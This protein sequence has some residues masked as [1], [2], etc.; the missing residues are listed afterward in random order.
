M[1]G[2]INAAFDNLRGRS[3]LD[4]SPLAEDLIALLSQYDQAEQFSLDKLKSGEPLTLNQKYVCLTQLCPSNYISEIAPILLTFDEYLI[5]S[6][7][8]SM[9][10][11]YKTRPKEFDEVC[12]A[13]LKMRRTRESNNLLAT[14]FQRIASKDKDYRSKLGRNGDKL[15][16]ELK[17]ISGSFIYHPW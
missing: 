16:E 5:E 12:E 2:E 15:S 8:D 6:V 13:I 17:R 10:Q 4:A 11:R 1:I 14:V 7:C 3:Y 9:E